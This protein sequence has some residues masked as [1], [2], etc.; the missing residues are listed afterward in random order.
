MGKERGL[1]IFKEIIESRF[2]AGNDDDFD[3]STIDQNSA[4]NDR[5][6]ERD[7]E[8]YWFDDEEPTKI[9]DDSNL[10]GQ[11]GVQDF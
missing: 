5:G 4:Y 8:E 6:M 3:Y 11:T 10:N 7:R 1:A 2:L 9:D